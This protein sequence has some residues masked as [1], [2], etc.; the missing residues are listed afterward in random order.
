MFILTG[1]FLWININTLL[2]LRSYIYIYINHIIAYII[3]RTKAGHP[4][5]VEVSVRRRG[6][7]QSHLTKAIAEIRWRASAQVWGLKLQPRYGWAVL[8]RTLFCL[9]LT[10]LSQIQR[11]IFARLR[12]T[13][14]FCFCCSHQRS[15]PIRIELHDFPPTIA[16][17]TYKCVTSWGVKKCDT[18]NQV[19]ATTILFNPKNSLSHCWSTCIIYTTTYTIKIPS[20]S[21]G[22]TYHYHIYTTLP[23]L[24]TK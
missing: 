15:H 18:D 4:F 12:L 11:A 16:S 19:C 1:C 3:Y 2:N 8:I 6:R 13:A 7:W 10:Y 17:I 20:H 24:Q 14:P 9:K 21:S 22:N 23:Q 5:L